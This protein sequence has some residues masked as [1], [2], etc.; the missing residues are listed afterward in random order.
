MTGKFYEPQTAIGEKAEA[1]AGFAG[2][3]AMPGGLARRIVG[4]VVAPF[5]GSEGLAAIPGIHGTALEAP[6]RMVGG[7]LGGV[8]SGV[9]GST[10]AA[11]R[12][13]AGH[14]PRA[15]RWTTPRSSRGSASS[16]MRTNL[17]AARR[18]ETPP[19]P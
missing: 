19:N 3:A 5:V 8:A 1:L 15:C 9:A 10:R 2:G 12:D 14:R 4:G 7:V 18:A 17:R 13:A 11:R 6:A 16:A